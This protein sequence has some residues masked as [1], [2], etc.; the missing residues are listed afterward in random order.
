MNSQKQNTSPKNDQ[1]FD[2]GHG[3]LN[4]NDDVNALELDM[5]STYRSPTKQQPQIL[6]SKRRDDIKSPAHDTDK[7]LDLLIRNAGEIDD[8]TKDLLVKNRTLIQRLF[9]SKMDRMVMEMQRNTVQNAMEFRLNLYKMSTQFRLEALREKY[10]AALMTIR[11]EYRVRVSEFMMGKLEDLHNVVDVK[12]RA[13]IEFAKRKYDNAQL[14]SG[15]PSLQALYLRNIDEQSLGYLN[16]LQRQITN[17][18]SIIDEQI[19][20][21]N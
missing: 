11:G 17:F 9:P 1:P 18:E 2:A 10:N 4:F 14:Q 20:R 6:Q 21:I 5:E 7:N 15:Y 3:S 12:E 16:F 19:E 8:R 13:F